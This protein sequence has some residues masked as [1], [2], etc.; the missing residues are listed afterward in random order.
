[1][2]FRLLPVTSQAPPTLPRPTPRLRPLALADS[3]TALRTCCLL[4]WE[5]ASCPLGLQ[6]RNPQNGLLSPPV[7]RYAPYPP[8][9][10]PPPLIYF[11]HSISLRTLLVFPWSVPPTHT[12]NARKDFVR[13]IGHSSQCLEPCLGQSSCSIRTQQWM[14][15]K[16]SSNTDGDINIVMYSR[17][18]LTLNTGK[19]GRRRGHIPKPCGSSFGIVLKVRYCQQQ[20][21][22]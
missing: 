17:N 22:E 13:L 16:M 9:A 1:M 19:E 15:N 3:P 4:W 2:K 12:Q 20:A 6:L 7:C 18:T 14:W 10:S 11:L 5:L 8:Q 21:S